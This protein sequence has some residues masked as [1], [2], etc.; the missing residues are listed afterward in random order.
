MDVEADARGAGA[1]SNGT[2]VAKRG[3][4]D[5][6]RA[7]R[8]RRHVMTLKRRTVA[9]KAPSSELVRTVKVLRWCA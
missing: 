2:R 7:R 9:V 1:R 6:E 8:N 5:V 3:G 4:G